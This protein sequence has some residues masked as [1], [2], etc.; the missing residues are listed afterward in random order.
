MLEDG[1]AGTFALDKEVDTFLLLCLAPFITWMK[2]VIYPHFG[3][4]QAQISIIVHRYDFWVGK[5]FLNDLLM[6]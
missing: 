5:P 4:F 1:H 6:I 2:A 3:A